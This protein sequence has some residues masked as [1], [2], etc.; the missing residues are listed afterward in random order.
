MREL[1]FTI[2]NSILEADFFKNRKK[3]WDRIP[4]FH[5]FCVDRTR[6]KI[7][8]TIREGGGGL[9]QKKEGNHE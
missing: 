8:I 2:R 5:I 1:D 6:R 4:T 9:F 7:V 3:K